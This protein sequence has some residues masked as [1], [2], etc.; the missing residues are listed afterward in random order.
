MLQPSVKAIHPQA[1]EIIRDSADARANRHLIV[2]QHD[3]QLGRLLAARVIQGLEHDAAWQRPVADH[4]DGMAISFAEKL[5]AA[6]QS[7]HGRDAASG[8]ARHEQIV[9]AFVRI[10]VAHQSAAGANRGK[11]AVAAGDEL[12]R[13]NLMAGV[14]NQA[15][16]AE[17]ERRVQGQAELDNAQVRSKM[18]RSIGDNFAQG[19]AHFAGE[20]LQ[21]RQRESLQVER[22]LNRGK[23][24]VHH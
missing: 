9:G 12:V 11:L 16:A 13:I 1:I 14:P 24:V 15:V 10:R 23:Q 8:M 3:Q 5:V 4:R 22:R 18:G 6:V 21:L 20:L 2:V 7:E 17:V 19:V